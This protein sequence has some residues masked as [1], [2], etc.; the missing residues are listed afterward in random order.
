MTPVTDEQM[1]RAALA[2]LTDDQPPMPPGRF[3]S[4]RG[5]AVRH[6]RRQLAGTVLTALAV[7]GIAVGIGRAPGILKPSPLGR[8]VPGWALPWPD[9]RNGSVPQ[10]VLNKAVLAWYEEAVRETAPAPLSPE[11]I[12]RQFRSLHVTWYLGQK[13]AR[14]QAV[15]VIF[16]ASSTA[17]GRQLV[18]GWASAS[19]VMGGQPAYASGGTPWQLTTTAAPREPNSFGP[20]ISEYLSGPSASGTGT[21]SW[22]VVLPAPGALMGTWTSTTGAGGVAVTG[23]RSSQVFTANAGQLTTDVLLWVGAA[24]T[25]VVPVGIGG[26]AAMPPLT[27]PEALTPPGSFREISSATG[28]GF[29]LNQDSSISRSGGPYAVLGRCYFTR[30]VDQ[31]GTARSMPSGHGP[32]T[33]TINGHNIGTIACDMQQ[34]ELAVPRS[35]LRPQGDSVGIVGNE[36]TSWRVAFGRVH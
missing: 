17:T 13:V 10:S 15:A 20:D 24:R 21:G 31:A 5:R 26:V 33:I 11:Q 16:E 27:P 3:Q 7:A 19:E 14:G 28:Q 30:L 35:L 2:D 23:A 12:A 8:T 34:H 4:V 18:V 29:E 1:M 9:Y 22:I 32:L 36:L 6:C 25:R